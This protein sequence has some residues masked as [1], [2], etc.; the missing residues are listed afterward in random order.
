MSVLRHLLWPIAVVYGVVLRIR[1]L[2][3]D[4]NI[5]PSRKAAIKSIALGN[6]A[7]G[8]TGKTPHTAYILELL[9][10]FEHRAFLSRGYGR[11]T[12]GFFR[13]NGDSNVEQVGDEP[14]L[15]ARRFP[16]L[17]CFVGE[18]RLTAIEQIA[19]QTHSNL[20]VLDDAL[21]HRKLQP[22]V[23]LMLTTWDQPFVDDALLPVGR[24]RDLKLRVKKADAVIVSKCPVNISK[25]DRTNM[26]NR[27]D[28][29]GVPVFYSRIAYGL[30]IAIQNGGSLS[31]GDSV[32][33]VT[34]IA[35]ADLFLQYV[36]SCYH[37]VD[38]MS[39]P[40]HASFSTADLAEWGAKKSGQ[41]INVLT[42]E[43]DAM[44]L[45]GMNLPQELRVFYIPIEVVLIG[46]GEEERLKSL[47]LKKIND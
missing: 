9:K 32:L 21:Q 8:G 42:T 36:N 33:V 22:D 28:L 10:E 7:L 40:D 24:L 14:L 3:F 17:D 20:V 4:A 11:K 16:Y 31:D 26:A 27:F 46:E 37:V 29:A 15:I 41:H 18:D 25:D 47:I 1:H 12:S 43:K 35:N 38:H 23:A 5:L 6:V 39:Y 34:G 45:F 2:L 44:R 13:I 30:P 19:H